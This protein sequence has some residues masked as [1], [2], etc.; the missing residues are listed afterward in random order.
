MKSPLWQGPALALGAAALFGISAP[1]GKLLLEQMSPLWLAGLLSM[2][3]GGG[4]GL[5]MLARRL[6]RRGSPKETPL[7]RPDLPWL[8]GSLLFGGFAA[9]ILLALGLAHTPAASASLLLNLEGVCTALIAWFVFGEHFDQRI[10]L[11]MCAILAGAALLSW[12]G[13]QVPGIP[14]SA[15]GIAGACLCWAIDNNLTRRISS[16]DPVQIT[17]LKGLSAGLVNVL[18]AILGSP[19]PPATSALLQGLALGWV[20]YGLSLVCFVLAL[21]HLGTSRTG[22]YFSVAPFLGTA[23][24]LLIE[25][26]LPP[27]LFWGAAALM[28]VG[29][30]LHLFEKH[31]HFHRHEALEHSHAH[32][33]DLHHQHA[34]SP[35]DPPGEPHTHW[36]RHEPMEHSHP[37]FP[38]IHHQH[39]HGPDDLTPP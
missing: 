3:S 33:H 8:A 20:S 27:P 29:V 38:D 17:T 2:G 39:S 10:F 11:G 22:A 6:L 19:A 26:Q 15:L 31:D 18:L 37:H 23:L 14:W 35:S 36:H 12:E 28:G 25:W 7:R 1:L 32:V 4:L 34:H 16:A 9:P 13:Q 5:W 24:S 30:W 21:R